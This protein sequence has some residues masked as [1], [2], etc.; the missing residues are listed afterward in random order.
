MKPYSL[1]GYAEMLADGIRRDAY[2]A[3]IQTVVRHGTSVL[4][5]GTGPGVFALHAARRGA[6]VVALETSDVIDIGRRLAD[7]NDLA[8]SVRFARTRSEDYETDHPFDVIVS[9]L[10]GVLP[11][12]P[13]NVASIADARDR[14]L[15]RGGCLI[16]TVDRLWAAVAD[17]EAPVRRHREGFR[18]RLGLDLRVAREL[19]D[20]GPLRVS[21][22]P[23][24]LLTEPVG[25]AEID[26]RVAVEGPVT[27]ALEMP[28][29][30]AGTAHGIALWFDTDLLPAPDALDTGRRAIGFDCGPG[31]PPTL[32]AQVLLPFPEPV[33]V[34]A[35][36]TVRADLDWRAIGPEGVW[37][38]RTRI[39]DRRFDQSTF[40]GT[41][42]DPDRLRRRAAG[43]LPRRNPDAEAVA[44]VLSR[45][46][47]ARSSQAIADALAAR[48]PARFRASTDALTFVANLADRFSI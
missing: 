38:W 26:Y 23:D 37:R 20:H 30:R 24:D 17:A 36:D 33:D 25:W 29:A 47:G 10:R 22:E 32:Y 39:G 6:R 40:E 41:V 34:T 3:A 5:I 11:L 8:G 1:A 19:L 21:L 43:F 9:D 4:E 35:R 14:L 46:D 27:A 31:A 18:D 16:P 15:A 45:M 13:G 42:F 48:F 28:V 12:E 44:F 7:A 2:A